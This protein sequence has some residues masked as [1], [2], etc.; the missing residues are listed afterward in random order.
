MELR[1]RRLVVATEYASEYVGQRIRQDPD[2]EAVERETCFH[3][4]DEDTEVQ[5]Q[6]CSA[7]IMRA[8][9]R[10]EGVS[11][12]KKGI[13][14]R[15]GEVVSVMGSFPITMLSIKSPRKTKSLSQVVS[16]AIQTTKDGGHTG[17]RRSDS[18]GKEGSNSPLPTKRGGANETF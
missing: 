17:G 9:I 18:C 6:T 7:A 4:S 5:F 13:E 8:L 12:K 10:S 16:P 1:Q 14:L 11:T 3:F 2:R 15:D